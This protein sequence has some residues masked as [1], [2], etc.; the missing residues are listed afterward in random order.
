MSYSNLK[1]FF[2]NYF[3]SNEEISINNLEPFEQERYPQEDE[4]LQFLPNIPELL[5]K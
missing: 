2:I 5:R 3:V 4:H 1:Y